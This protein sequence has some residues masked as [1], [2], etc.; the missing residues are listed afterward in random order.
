MTSEEQLDALYS[1]AEVVAAER[2]ASPHDRKDAA[3]E[4]RIAAWRAVSSHPDMGMAYY[5]TAV[6]NAV[7][8]FL[9]GRSQFGATGRRGWSSVRA[10]LVAEFDVRDH[11]TR[12]DRYP[13]EESE[14]AWDAARAHCS[15]G[16]LALL[17]DVYVMGDTMREASIARGKNREWAGEVLRTRILPKLKE[18]LAA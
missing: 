4:G 7:R 10:G 8:G 5:R 6:K 3:Q 9:S 11:P 13:V 16:E 15:E 14:G 17:A 18:A 2:V 1:F 12:L